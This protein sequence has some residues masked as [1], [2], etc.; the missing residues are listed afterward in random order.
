MLYQ[1]HQ[2]YMEAVS[3]LNSWMQQMQDFCNHQWSPLNYTF[4][5]KTIAATAEVIERCTGVYDRPEFGIEYAD[6]GGNKIAIKEDIVISKPYCNLLH[7]KRNG[8]YDHPKVLL[9]APMSGHYSTLLRGTV[10]HFI[11]D[12]EVY[13]TDW[14]NARDVPL[15]EGSFSFDDYVSY[16]IDFCEH[17]KGDFHIVAV[18]QP[19]VPTVVAASV[20][21]QHKSEFQPKSMSLLGGPIDTRVSP[22]EVNE[23]AISKELEWFENNVICTVP[24]NFPGAGQRVYPGFIQLTGFLS[25]NLDNH[26]NKHFTF[27]GDLVKGDGDS[28][29]NHRQFYNEYLAVMDMPAE[30]YLDTIRH[31]FIEHQ[32]P[33]GEITYQGELIDSTTVTDV[34]LL[35]IEGEKDDITGAG[36]TE[37]AHDILTGIPKNMKQHY[38][39]P[40]V[41]HY[42][43]FNGRRFRQEIGPRIKAFIQQYN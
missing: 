39:Q 14:I 12:H 43:V 9:I 29:E 37:A 42:G 35:T 6:I 26:I 3:P 22:T 23:Y 28:A 21:A 36:Q 8:D 38:T 41:G 30:F 2:R 5:G 7:F 34:A 40:E 19:T 33:K 20:M 11:G 1:I 25:M 15:S 16:L 4:A 27:F 10:E 32:L 18:C 17:L 24:D 31:V 13:I